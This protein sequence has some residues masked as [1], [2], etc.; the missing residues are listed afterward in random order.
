MDKKLLFIAPKFYNYH[1][2]IKGKLQILLKRKVD[3]Y[4]DRKI[5]LLYSL[6]NTLNRDFINIYQ[7]IYYLLLWIKVRNES[8]SHL[9]VIKGYDIPIFFLLKLKKKNINIKT[10]MYQWDPMDKFNYQKLIPFFDKIFTFD[11]RDYKNY[12]NLNFLQLFYTEDIKK[13]SESKST[14]N[15]DFFYIS[16]FTEERYDFLEKFITYCKENNHTLKYYL[17]VPYT[18]FIKHKYFKGIKLKN[19]NLSFKPMGREEYLECLQNCSV[20]VDYN[21]SDQAGLSMRVIEAYGSNRKV[22]STNSFIM[23]DPISSKTWVS[24]LN[25]NSMH[26]SEYNYKNESSDSKHN[27][28]IDNWLKI[29]FENEAIY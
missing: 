17:Y 12:N 21:H 9:F 7:Y 8:Y 18:T 23:K 27:L 13:I 22:L 10:I 29:L 28:F 24:F 26:Y 5:N 14:P 16:S 19:R 15:I 25:Q 11:Y 4:E 20:V 2:Q 1:I 3:Y 6:L